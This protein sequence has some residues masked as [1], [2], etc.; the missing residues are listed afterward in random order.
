MFPASDRFRSRIGKANRWV[1]EV[2]WSNGGEWAPV[3]FVSGTVTRSLTS[4]V[5]WT[6]NLSLADAPR[7]LN[8][9]Q[10]FNTRMRIRHG[11]QFASGDVEWLPFGTFRVMTANTS[12]QSPVTTV[13]GESYESFLIAAE[14]QRP[15]KFRAGN[16]DALLRALVGGTFDEDHILWTIPVAHLKN[17]PIPSV[18]VDGS[19]WA[20]ID[21]DGSEQSRAISDAL[22]VRI[23]AD[24][25]GGLIV[26]P[27]PTLQD[28]AV[29]EIEAGKLIDSTTSLT[30]AGV[31]NTVVAKGASTDGS[32]VVGPVTVRDNNPA[33]PTYWARPITDGGFGTATFRLT[34]PLL[35]TEE[36]LVKAASAKLAQLVGLRQQVAFDGVHNPLTEPGDV[37]IH[38][39]Q[40]VILDSVTYDLTGRTALQADTRAQATTLDGSVWDL[41]S[42]EGGQ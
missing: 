24:A 28:A 29:G 14:M 9:I 41:P 1:N 7:G 10:A 30:N 5:H 2:T 17:E 38:D 12:R 35:T 6:C 25:Y 20:L 18:L 39:G 33:S 32:K 42:T 31:A 34:N 23:I 21:G 16:A 8:G 27:V 11:I 13:T 3:P 4:Q 40:L 36:R 19:R 37:W 15:I 26:I 22:G